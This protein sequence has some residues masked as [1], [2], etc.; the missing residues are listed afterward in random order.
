MVLYHASQLIKGDQG[1]GREVFGGIFGF[2]Y[3]GV[4]F[5]FV[6]SGFIIFFIHANDQGGGRLI[7]YAK[8]RFIRIYPIYWVITLLTFALYVATQSAK[9]H[10]MLN[11]IFLVGANTD[12]ILAVAWT[13]FH[14]ILFY[15][16][17]AV[18][19]INRTAGAMLLALWWS[20][21][22]VFLFF[23][24]PHYSL[25]PINIL[26][27][28]GMS[29]YFISNRWGS[30]ALIL[31]GA[32][33]FILV[34]LEDVWIKLLSTNVRSMMYG[35]AASIF[36]VG[37]V[38]AHREKRN[39]AGLKPL[40]VLGD[41]SYSLYLIHYPVL[42]VAAKV[43]RVVDARMP[44]PLWSIYII[45]VAAGVT[46]GIV[47]HYLIEKRLLKRISPDMLSFRRRIG[48]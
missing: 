3:S 6:L 23:E 38:A 2:G 16:L 5:F 45:L 20:M 9:S 11:S 21:C 29:A 28:M 19:I 18:L 32:L 13:L 26:F 27:G 47:T 17:F 25:A 24:P 15:A 41:T 14:E 36:V 10:L 39:T 4:H 12:A 7:N 31:V 48:V 22:A 40:V 42:A 43:L 8:K 35:L 1:W 34:G 33:A 46:A 37:A 44:L 30:P